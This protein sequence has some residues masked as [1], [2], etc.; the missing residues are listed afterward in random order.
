MT[1][2]TVACF[3]KWPEDE[4]SNAAYLFNRWLRCQRDCESGKQQRWVK[5]TVTAQLSSNKQGAFKDFS[6]GKV[7]WTP[8]SKEY[9]CKTIAGMSGIQFQG[10]CSYAK[11]E[12]QNFFK[13]ESI[14]GKTSVELS[15]GYNVFVASTFTIRWKSKAG[16][17][18]FE[19]ELR[20]KFPLSGNSAEKFTSSTS[21]TNFVGNGSLA[22]TDKDSNTHTIISPYKVNGQDFYDTFVILDIKEELDPL[23]GTENNELEGMSSNSASPLELSLAALLGCALVHYFSSEH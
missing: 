23:R 8:A 7:S 5:T 22:V 21:A 6:D 1:A 12:T 13:E 11:L 16:A 10:E 20:K 19:A 18:R 3:Q 17:D 15:G 4:E 2:D 14:L 9:L